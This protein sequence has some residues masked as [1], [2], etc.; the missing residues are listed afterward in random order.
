MRVTQT[1]VLFLL[2]QRLNIAGKLTLGSQQ[3]VGRGQGE[4]LGEEEP[5]RYERFL[6]VL[7]LGQA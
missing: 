2:A 4:I 5:R 3:E 6:E 1:V 7:W